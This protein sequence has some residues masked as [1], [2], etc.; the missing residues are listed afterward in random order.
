MLQEKLEVEDYV[1]IPQPVYKEV[2]EKLEHPSVRGAQSSMGRPQSSMVRTQ[3][4]TEGATTSAGVQSSTGGEAAL[5]GTQS[6]TGGAA[7]AIAVAQSLMGG[8]AAIEGVQSSIGGAQASQPSESLKQVSEDKRDSAEELNN[9]LY[10]LVRHGRPLVNHDKQGESDSDIQN[11]N[12]DSSTNISVS[13]SVRISTPQRSKGSTNKTS[14]FSGEEQKVVNASVRLSAPISQQV[15]PAIQTTSVGCSE[16]SIRQSENSSGTQRAQK[17][18]VDDENQSSDSESSESSW[19][20]GDGESFDEGDDDFEDDGKKKK[21]LSPSASGKT[22]FSSSH[23]LKEAVAVGSKTPSALRKELSRKRP[24]ISHSNE[25]F[26][27]SPDTVQAG[28]RR[29]RFSTPGP[30]V[31]TA[32][33]SQ[34]LSSAMGLHIKTEHKV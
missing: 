28:K 9:A 7:A 30:L 34:Q 31:S 11:Q 17:Q 14:N 33:H 22:P 2:P 25:Q 29:A 10:G 21:R 23:S 12:A 1:S 13:T 19:S 3:S 5:A 15:E 27:T 32:Q 18:S 16:S 20:S 24:N 4:L 8:A 6:S 26:N